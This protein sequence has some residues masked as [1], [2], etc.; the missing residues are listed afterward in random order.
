MTRFISKNGEVVDL[1]PT[2]DRI[3]SG[4]KFLHRN[5]GAVFK[6]REGLLPAKPSGYYRGFVIETPGVKGAGSQRIVK[7]QGG[8]LFYT[9]DHYKTFIPIN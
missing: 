5:D 8:E 6:N 1:K 7:G 4:G 2:L 9:P 3:A